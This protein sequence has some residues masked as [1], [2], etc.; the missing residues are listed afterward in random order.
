MEEKSNMAA[1]HLSEFVVT[2]SVFLST[3]TIFSYFF[4]HLYLL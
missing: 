3:L 4:L 1:V 2:S